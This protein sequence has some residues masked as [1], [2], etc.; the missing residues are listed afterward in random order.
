MNNLPICFLC[1]LIKQ[2]QLIATSSIIAGW[3]IAEQEAR[4]IIVQCMW[5]SNLGF[6]CERSGKQSTA[7]CKGMQLQWCRCMIMRV[8]CGEEEIN[9]GTSAARP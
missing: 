1:F 4:Q 6:V 3:H 8:G 9:Q 2:L 7:A 5:S